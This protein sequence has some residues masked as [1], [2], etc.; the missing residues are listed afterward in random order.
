MLIYIFIQKQHSG[1][2]FMVTWSGGG[3]NMLW[4]NF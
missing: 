2:V 3:A 1:S 4:I